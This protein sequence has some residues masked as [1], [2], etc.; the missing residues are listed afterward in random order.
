MNWIQ[1]NINDNDLNIINNS[2][3]KD[4]IY[5]RLCYEMNTNKDLLKT[6]INDNMFNI[7]S[8]C[9]LNN[10]IT[11][12]EQINSLL[13]NINSSIVSPYK[14][15]NAEKAADLIYTY[16]N[17]KDAYI[18]IYADY[19]CDGISSGYICYSILNDLGHCYIELKYP[20][21]T[22]GYGLNMEYCDY[23]INNYKDK[24]VLV[25]TVDNGITK[26]NEIDKLLKANINVLVTDHHESIKE[27]LPNCLIVNPCN[28]EE[29]QEYDYSY[30]CGCGVIFKVCE[31]LQHK[32]NKDTMLEYT[33][34]LAI[35]TL[36]D[37]M[38]L[39][40]EN[41]AFIQYG[42]DIINSNKCPLGIKAI[43]DIQDINYLTANDI[44]W[45]LAP[46]INAC[47]RLN[48]TELGS[49]LFFLDEIATPKEIANKIIKV[50]ESRKNKSKSTINKIN[51]NYDF[52]NDNIVFLYDLKI[53]PGLIGSIAGKLTEIYNKPSIIAIKKGDIYSASIR[54]C[55]NINIIKYIEELKKK[56]IILSFGGHEQ[57]CACSFT[58]DN[59]T[60]I[61]NYF[62]S[63]SLTPSTEEQTETLAIN[64][65]F[66]SELSPILF[67]DY[68]F[69]LIN[70]IP[71]DNRQYIAPI[72]CIKDATILSQKIYAS[73][74]GE[75]KLKKD[76]K[77]FE[78]SIFKDLSDK[79]K[80]DI[81]PNCI[82]NKIT[83]YGQLTQKKFMSSG[84][85]KSV[86]SLA[87]NDI[88]I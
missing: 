73:G 19:D 67:N 34:Y 9:L 47:G 51:K 17:N 85:K 35:A 74:Y 42:L 77:I 10:N 30:L 1:N 60:N 44:L 52:S 28:R 61:I 55:N 75:I 37:V 88:T 29:E 81:L 38:P 3:N 18:F 59:I 56:N 39:S 15:H 66:I 70:L 64:N 63:L 24:E 62:N 32:Y 83:I 21:R 11:T 69:N 71:Y 23:I 20:N 7:F 13:N 22:D 16:L 14:L 40:N 72:F 41:I 78:I 68:F 31:I 76:N 80:E 33:P 43:M 84:F 58:E 48:N 53:E 6:I 86:Y 49:K 27:E 5:D 26:R 36:A 50:N 45:T 12:K 2:L 82:D 79:F 87:I 25:I 65:T 4:F 57:A 54:S 8:K 46:M